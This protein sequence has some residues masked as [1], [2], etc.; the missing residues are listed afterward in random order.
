MTIKTHAG[1]IT[2]KKEVLIRIANAFYSEALYYEG[3]GFTYCS[4]DSATVG[5]EI[6]K[7]VR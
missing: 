2:A 5:D 3:K 4:D 1:T 6:M 7:E